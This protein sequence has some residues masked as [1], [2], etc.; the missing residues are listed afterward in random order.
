MCPQSDHVQAK[1]RQRDRENP[2]SGQHRCPA[3]GVLISFYF[4]CSWASAEPVM[5]MSDGVTLMATSWVQDSELLGTLDAQ[6]SD[7]DSKSI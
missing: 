1:R 4:R 5:P 3:L 2:P 7:Q 6:W